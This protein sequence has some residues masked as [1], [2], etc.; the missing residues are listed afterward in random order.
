MTKEERSEYNKK[1][2]QANK[3]ERAAYNKAWNDANKEKVAAIYQAKKDSYYT[4]YYLKE[5][6]Y[7]GM[8]SRLYY[9]LSEHKS[10]HNRHVE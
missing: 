9:R 2:H 4:V 8:T 10:V 3:E 5:E 7:A 6:H 1:Y